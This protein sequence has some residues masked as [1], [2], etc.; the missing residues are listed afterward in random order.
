MSR[1]D[2]P[3]LLS[4]RNLQHTVVSSRATVGNALDALLESKPSIACFAAVT[5]AAY[6]AASGDDDAVAAAANAAVVAAND[7][8]VVAVVVG[9]NG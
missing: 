5:D 4:L 1:N 2:E 6:L 9:E 3:N 7:D 8:A